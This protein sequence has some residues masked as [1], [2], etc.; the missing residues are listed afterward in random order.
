M[1]HRTDPALGNQRPG[2]LD[3][4]GVAIGQVDHAD[5]PGGLDGLRHL[6]GVGGVDR[7][8]FFAEYVPAGGDQAQGGR[9]VHRVRGDIGHGVEAA[10][11]QRR[12]EI[13]ETP[14]DAVFLL[15]RRQRGR[16]DIGGG[17]DLAIV[18]RGEGNRMAAGHEPGAQNQ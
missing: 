16:V 5:Q 2:L 6:G 7:Q 17:D 8:G 1:A 10:P 4:R 15:E 3:R 18:N 14:L 9:V 13:A 12:L 11:R